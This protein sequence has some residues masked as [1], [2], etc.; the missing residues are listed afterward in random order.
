MKD[1]PSVQSCNHVEGSTA[2]IIVQ[3]GG[4]VVLYDQRGTAE[5]PTPHEVPGC[6]PLFVNRDG[7]LLDLGEWLVPGSGPTRIIVVSGLKG[8]GTSSVVRRWVELQPGRYPGGEVYVD[9]AAL[10]GPSGACDVSEGLA[11]CLRTAF[12]VTKDFLPATLAERTNL[13]RTHA[14]RG[15]PLLVVLDDVTQPAQIRPFIPAAPG[16][17]VLVTSS[18]RLDELVGDG[19]R[20]MPLKPLDAASGVLLLAKV[21]GEDR[22]AAEREAAERLVEL[23][24]GLP[25]ALTIAGTRLARRRRLGLAA[26]ADELAQEDGRL[27]ALTGGERSVSAAVSLTCSDLPAEALR[28]YR[29][30]ALLPGRGFDAETAAALNGCSVATAEALLEELDDASL[31]ED[32]VGD[33]RY[34]L[35]DLVRLHAR[36][37]AEQ[38]E[39]EEERHAAVRRVIDLHVVRAAFADRAIMGKRLRITDHDIVLAGH[40]DPFTGPGARD[41]ALTWLEAERA[42]LLAAVRVAHARGLD[43]QAWQL[44]ES[45]TALYFH[46]RHLADWIESGTLG[47]D[48]AA[49]LGARDAEARLRS[50]VSRPLMDVGDADRARE[51]IEKAVELAEESTHPVLRASVPEFAG[52]YWDHVDQAR[53]LGWYELSL[54]RNIEADEPRGAALA[55]LFMGSTLLASGEHERAVATLQEAYGQL[56]GLGDA[57]MA[58]RA[59]AALGHAYD[60]LGRED[61][62]VRALE[63]AA[64]MLNATQAVYYE[65]QVREESA[66][67]A[68]RRADRAAERRHV[69]RALEIHEAGGSRRAGELRKRLDGLA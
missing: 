65:A 34:T 56:D 25:I 42:D 22:V 6:T 44:A 47:A 37:L 62:A 17:A 2:E 46:H 53:A 51:Q 15:G 69:A 8:I 19:A 30:L 13:Y 7:E 66:D 1:V 59:L 57:R 3:A 50:L 21:C 41:A 5:P 61:E 63:R 28:L 43:Q 40:E 68:R 4:D 39:P 36:S 27:A 45:L 64:D 20:L 18:R 10:R 12:G 67:M 35:H 38:D 54:Q 31:L 33:F 60:S 24:G 32:A 14:A 48:S 55:R 52:R 9:F 26:L 49:R 11:Q 29:R 16:S 23:C 58:G